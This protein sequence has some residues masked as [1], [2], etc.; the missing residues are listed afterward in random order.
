[1]L[2]DDE[3][4]DRV[5]EAALAPERWIDV[6]EDITRI[7]DS[8]GTLLYA[9][10][11]KG[12]S[13]LAT[14]GVRSLFKM[15]QDLPDGVVNTRQELLLT[16]PQSQFHS[17]A[18]YFSQS[19]M[20]RDPSYTE[21]L[22]PMG[23]GYAAATWI[24]VPSG[25]NLVFSLE[26]RRDRGAYEPEIIRRLT[27]L[28]PHLA[29]SALMASRM[30]FERIQTAN[31]AFQVSGLPAAALTIDGRVIDC[32]ELFAAQTDQV[33]IGASDRLVLVNPHAQELLAQS[34]ARM[35][36]REPDF[37]QASRS[38]PL[39]RT[40][41]SAAA[42]MHLIPVRR[43]ARDLFLRAALFL[44]MT[45]VNDRRL[46]PQSVIQGLFDL[47]TAETK[48]AMSLADRQTVD[49]MALKLGVS[50]ETVRQHLKHIFDKTGFSRQSD[51]AATISTIP[52]IE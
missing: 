19:D 46:P 3:V 35:K 23:L 26:R 18:D 33:K 36:L 22:W 28:R 1:M 12:V 42:V 51:L 2:T 17:D 44:V 49:E 5:Y 21:L 25:D 32:N 31:R 52:R 11:E 45:P 43:I 30:D 16:L 6:L 9:A 48:V 39:P 38:L 24:S 47:T 40:E 7:S 13:G 4:I 34:L 8:A 14:H 15:V 37:I 27:M 41:Q 50:R 20:E 10:R 29:R